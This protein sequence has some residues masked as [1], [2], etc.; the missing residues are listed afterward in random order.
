MSPHAI[1]D[2]LEML[3]AALYISEGWYDIWFQ[4]R[5]SEERR[6]RKMATYG[7]ARAVVLFD[8]ALNGEM[9]A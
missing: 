6:L 9:R 2:H 3:F 7:R 4:Q 5:D 1:G 8:R